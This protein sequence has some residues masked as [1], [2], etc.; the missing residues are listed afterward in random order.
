METQLRTEGASF[1]DQLFTPGEV[2]YCECKR[3]P[4]RHFAARLAAKEALF[5]ALAIDEG[6]VQRWREV[7]IRNEPSG[8]PRAVL[9]GL[10]REL[11][12]AR[13]V[14]AIFI[15]MSHTA[16]L[17]AATVVLESRTPPAPTREVT[18]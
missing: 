7:E 5:K 1:R 17:A 9:H 8:R 6:Q 16:A 4:A 10:V 14:D 2:A 12:H 13:R 3:Y 11:A 15:S 18:G